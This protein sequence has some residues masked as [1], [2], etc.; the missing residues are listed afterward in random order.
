MDRECNQ[1]RSGACPSLLHEFFICCFDYMCYPVYVNMD[2]LS[3]R[4][5][6]LIS[7]MHSKQYRIHIN[8]CTQDKYTLY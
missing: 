5:L 8:K 3:P 2:L 7:E 1:K 6:H 4:V